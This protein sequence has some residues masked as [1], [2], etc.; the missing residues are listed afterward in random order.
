MT[1]NPHLVTP[2]VRRGAAP[3]HAARA[4]L[5]VHGRGQDP[6]FMI[7]VADRIGMA[8]VHCVFPSAAGGSWYPGRFMDL[9]EMNEPWLGHALDAIDARQR[10][11]EAAGFG[12][13]RAIL[14]G[15][16]QGACLLAEYLV[17]VPRAYGAAVLLTGGYLG[18]NGQVKAAG[19]RL[20]GT[21]VLLSSSV[22][23]EWVPPGRVRETAEL[24]R[25]MGA[26]VTLRL[27]DAPD[28]GVSDEEVLAVRDL[29]ADAAVGRSTEPTAG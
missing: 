10:E 20:P 25:R 29:L 21:A 3:E 18:P 22:V 26:A 13:D 6:T 23:D 4:A 1:L 19:G 14:I 11:L 16:S 5:F 2:V 7:G 15:F 9:P 17:R 28:H 8:G 24:L 27:H 12:P